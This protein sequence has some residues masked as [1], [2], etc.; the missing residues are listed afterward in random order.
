MGIFTVPSISLATFSIITNDVSAKDWFRIYYDV[1][2][3]GLATVTFIGI[4]YF[5]LIPRGN[6]RF[7]QVVGTIVITG[8]VTRTATRS[9]IGLPDFLPLFTALGLSIVAD[10]FLWLFL[11]GLFWL[12]AF[13]RNP[14]FSR[15]RDGQ[16]A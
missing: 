11:G 4:I 7:Y 5:A 16:I 8:I 12:I 2:A 13:Y 10:L 9:S 3:A 14:Q 15:T 1:L 6:V